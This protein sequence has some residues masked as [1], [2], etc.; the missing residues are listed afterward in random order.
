MHC[1]MMEFMSRFLERVILAISS[2]GCRAR[3][4][5]S[6][7]AGGIDRDQNPGRDREMDASPDRLVSPRSAGVL[8]APAGG[9]R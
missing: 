9:A 4:G 2:T 5:P 3:I 8:M 1:L 6:G 7:C